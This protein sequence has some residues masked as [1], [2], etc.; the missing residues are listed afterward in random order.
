MTEV[1][2]YR[3]GFEPDKSSRGWLGVRVKW[4]PGAGGFDG[5]MGTVVAE[6]VRAGEFGWMKVRP[7][8]PDGDR[9]PDGLPTHTTEVRREGQ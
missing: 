2:K 7:D 3:P 5:Q 1:R 8:G 9:W 4:L 6:E